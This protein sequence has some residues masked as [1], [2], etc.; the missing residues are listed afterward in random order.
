MAKQE[1]QNIS[2]NF[3]TL[4]NSPEQVLQASADGNYVACLLSPGRSEFNLEIPYEIPAE[5]T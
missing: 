4:K 2:G 5:Y 1:P 3:K